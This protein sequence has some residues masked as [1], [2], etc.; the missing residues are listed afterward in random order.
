MKSA[1]L[2]LQVVTA[3]RGTVSISISISSDDDDDQG[4]IARSE[5]ILAGI[6]DQHA[7]FAS[8][9]LSAFLYCSRNDITEPAKVQ[10]VH[11]SIV[12]DVAQL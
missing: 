12:E 6:G 7:C 1:R 11:R 2:H 3:S 8:A 4:R 5:K 9:S 10:D